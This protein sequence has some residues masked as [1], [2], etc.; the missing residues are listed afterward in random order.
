MR[1]FTLVL[2]FVLSI[3][4]IS[5]GEGGGSST[6][7]SSSSSYISS[8]SSFSSSSQSSSSSISSASSSLVADGILKEQVVDEDGAKVDAGEI[9]LEIPAGALKGAK[10]LSITKESGEYKISGLQDGVDK[11][12]VVG[13]ALAN[14]G[15]YD[16]KS[17]FV[18]FESTNSCYAASLHQY[19]D[20]FAYLDTYKEG[21]FLKAVIPQDATSAIRSKLRADEDGTIRV[22]VRSN[23]KSVLLDEGKYKIYLNR[24]D[25]PNSKEN[26]LSNIAYDAG[27]GLVAADTKLQLMGFNTGKIKRP[28][29]IYI[30]SAADDEYIVNANGYELGSLLNQFDSYIVIAR[31]IYSTDTFHGTLGHEY[32]HAIQNSYFKSFNE[33]N[34]SMQPN[35]DYAWLMEASSVWIEYEMRDY[36]QEY[37]SPRASGW[38]NFF[39]Y[40][41]GAD[42]THRGYF[43]PPD[44]DQMRFRFEIGYGMGLFFRYLSANVGWH[45][46]Y[47]IWLEIHKG[48]KSLQAIENAYE[49]E[50]DADI[51]P[52]GLQE[53]WATFIRQYFSKKLPE[54]Y[55]NHAK[56]QISAPT[57]LTVDISH[58]GDDMKT[59]FDMPKL[60]AI[61]VD[62]NNTSD[63]KTLAQM[64]IE[65]DFPVSIFKISSN[66]SDIKMIEIEK[67]YDYNI[68]LEPKNSMSIGVVNKEG[69]TTMSMD[70]NPVISKPYVVEKPTH[71]EAC[72][73]HANGED[74]RMGIILKHDKGYDIYYKVSSGCESSDSS[75][76][77]DNLM[78]FAPSLRSSCYDTDILYD[79]YLYKDGTIIYMSNQTQYITAVA[80]S[81]DDVASG[82]MYYQYDPYM[83]GKCQ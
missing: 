14:M 62:I 6:E 50:F 34:V 71:E 51:Y 73:A 63:K 65:T 59:N 39:V 57:S 20:C 19:V 81:P 35:N 76:S 36:P 53:G 24:D 25:F 72:E 23:I 48:K 77:S 18:S 11:P 70:F 7:V 80:V 55:P 46:I 40:G 2:F 17:T 8:S 45:I 27:V 30:R 61:K 67:S 58:M 43:L 64:H 26:N 9:I 12:V 42:F 31:D 74:D 47:D 54:L 10:T 49:K 16:P 38:N 15:E 28:L 83:L 52:G 22:S 75:D 41:L 29:K 32:F 60:S 68:T 79:S 78:D 21:D 44:A 82:M 1:A 37:T 66:Y 56:W 33:Y 13:F 4:F 69:Y 3:F 5:C